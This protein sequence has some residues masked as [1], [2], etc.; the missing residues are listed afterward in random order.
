MEY[1][2]T[3]KTYILT[4]LMCKTL[5]SYSHRSSSC[6]IMM[7]L[8]HS[9]N[10]LL[11]T[12]RITQRAVS[13]IRSEGKGLSSSHNFWTG[14]E[15][16]N[17]C[18]FIMKCKTYSKMLLGLSDYIAHVLPIRSQLMPLINGIISK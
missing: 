5:Y 4:P 13:T 8:R 14:Y 7:G 10:K 2:R 12:L 1:F 9:P 11:H 18:N 15:L 3:V 17:T 16:L 6:T